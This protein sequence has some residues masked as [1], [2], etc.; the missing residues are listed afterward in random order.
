[1]L[2]SAITESLQKIVTEN[3]TEEI[4]GIKRKQ[5]EIVCFVYEQ[6]LLHRETSYY[7]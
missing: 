5:M 2:Q 7:Y 6:E 1:M 3:L 4:K